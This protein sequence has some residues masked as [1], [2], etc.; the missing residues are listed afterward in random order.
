MEMTERV[1]IRSWVGMIVAACIVGGC[2]TGSWGAL[3]NDRIKKPE[4][5][6]PGAT[7]GFV[8]PSSPIEREKMERAIEILEARGYRTKIPKGLFESDGYVAGSDEGRAAQFVA[9]MTDPEVDA[10]FAAAGGYGAMR[11]LPHVDFDRLSEPRL[12]TGFSDITAIHLALLSECGW[13]SFHSPNMMDGFGQGEGHKA[14]TRSWFWSMLESEGRSL[15]V[16][17]DPVAEDSEACPVPAP[18]VSGVSRGR[19]VGGN[20]SL[21]SALVGTDYELR[22]RNRILF[23]EDVGERPYRID[24]MLSQMQLAGQFDQLAGVVLGQFT[25]CEP[26]KEGATWDV[27]R[28]LRHYFEELGVPVLTNFPS[29][30]HHFN[31]IVPLGYHVELDAT[32]GEI[33]LLESLWR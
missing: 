1:R 33:R 25:D 10:V 4:G 16:R 3:R 7:I 23:L 26:T 14:S 17:S 13:A 31:S 15:T 2:A 29:G 22:T 30:H 11:M 24:R 5:L 32:Q 8:S 6:V 20:L 12:V 9:V 27:D 21:V 28:V 18:M 19:L